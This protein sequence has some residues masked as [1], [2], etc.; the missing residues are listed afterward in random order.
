MDCRHPVEV[1]HYVLRKANICCSIL[2]EY[3][4]QPLQESILFLWSKMLAL[5]DKLDYKVDSVED[6]KGAIEC[7]GGRPKKR[8][9]QEF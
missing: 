5:E 4:V 6:E 3:I 9:D 7:V 8:P 2:I 1:S